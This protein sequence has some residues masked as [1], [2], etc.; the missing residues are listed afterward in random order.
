MSEA[1]FD[2]LLDAVKMAMEPAAGDDFLAFA[3]ES[4][5]QMQAA[6]DNGHAWPLIPFPEDWY[7][8]C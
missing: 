1:E 6:N 2:R 8:A 7:A 3:P 5:E 4:V